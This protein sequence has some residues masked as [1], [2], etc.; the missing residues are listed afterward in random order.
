MGII[1][2]MK[3]RFSHD[4]GEGYAETSEK[5]TTVIGYF[6][7]FVMFV[8][9]IIVGQSVFD[10]L[11]GLVD[12]PE[13]PSSCA[14]RLVN[15]GVERFMCYDS[16]G[17]DCGCEFGAIDAEYGL[18]A[19]I[20]AQLPN[21]ATLETLAET[22]RT[23][24][25]AVREAERTLR[26]AERQYELSLSERTAGVDS[27]IEPGQE[28]AIVAARAVLAERQQELATLEA[29]QAALAAAVE[30]ELS[31]L[32][33]S[34]EAALDAF[35]RA[36]VGYKLIVF[37]LSLLFIVPVFAVALRYYLRA[38]RADS[39]YTIIFGTFLAAA[40]ILLLQVVLMFLFEILPLEW[41]A[42]VLSF[43]ATIPFFR[44]IFYYA[45]VA[46]VIALFGGIVF[47]IQRRIFNTQRVALRRL[48]KN[49]CPNCTFT[50][51]R[52]D[53]YCPGCGVKLRETCTS[54]GNLRSVHTRYCNHCGSARPQT[55]TE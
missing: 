39:P 35:E 26:E 14:A 50:I 32:E 22:I 51:H 3:Q 12:R 34:Y 47:F 28:A 15:G 5:K 44:F 16:R 52:D 19:Q 54:C 42:D 27:I 53:G 23:E 11:S 6:F 33:V 31:G 41:L 38:K 43:L 10:D 9:L 2:R 29:E 4:D 18:D 1:S 13:R 36:M 40:A 45:M 46:L 48:R 21:L 30:A 20:T 7:L 8:F 17:S 24:E 25:L 37:V 49:E 55:T